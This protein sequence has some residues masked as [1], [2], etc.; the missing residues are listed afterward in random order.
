MNLNIANLIIFSYLLEFWNEIW[1]VYVACSVEQELNIIFNKNTQLVH[2][3][4]KNI[5]FLSKINM[6]EW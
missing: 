6:D 3:T 2:K 4:F 1:H 5:I